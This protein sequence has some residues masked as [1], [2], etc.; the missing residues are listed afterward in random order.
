MDDLKFEMT[1]TT[2]S[3]NVLGIGY[4]KEKNVMRVSFKGGSSYRYF[5]VDEDLFLSVKNA[6]SVGSYL[7]HHVKGKFES[8]KEI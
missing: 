7:H 1:E 4:N 2:F 3:S 5:G 8:V 6:K